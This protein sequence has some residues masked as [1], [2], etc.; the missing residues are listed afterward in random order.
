[1]DFFD[2]GKSDS[3]IILHETLQSLQVGV[4]LSNSEMRFLIA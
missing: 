1:M 3:Y 2:R 4:G